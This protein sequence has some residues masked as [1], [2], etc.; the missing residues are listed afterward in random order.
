[1]FGGLIVALCVACVAAT[2]VTISNVLPRRDTAG[3]ILDAHD[4]KVLHMNGDLC[5]MLC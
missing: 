5:G 4:G 2:A 3:N 1:M